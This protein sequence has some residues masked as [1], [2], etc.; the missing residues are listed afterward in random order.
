[1]LERFIEQILC[2]VADGFLS[3]DGLNEFLVL[4]IEI[5]E[6]IALAEAYAKGLEQKLQEAREKN[7]QSRVDQ[8]TGLLR[9]AYQ[10][11]HTLKEHM[12]EH[13]VDMRNAFADE[14]EGTTPVLQ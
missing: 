8:F 7:D 3:T 1:M 12:Q 13:G 2:A 4:I 9:E 10:K 5:G 6:Q 14:N 11:L